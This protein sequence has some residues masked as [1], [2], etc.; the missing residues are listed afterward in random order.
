[1]SKQMS[2]WIENE[3]CLL[4]YTA[5]FDIFVDTF[6]LVLE[7]P[8]IH[9]QTIKHTIA[10]SCNISSFPLNFCLD[11]RGLVTLVCVLPIKLEPNLR[12]RADLVSVTRPRSHSPS[13]PDSTTP[14]GCT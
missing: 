6:F 1:V 13:S 3:P 7:F 4:T 14:T 5:L 11:G 9:T 12:R 2:F 8:H 10:P